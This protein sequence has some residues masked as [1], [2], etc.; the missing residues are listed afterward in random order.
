MV[1]GVYVL[2]GLC[3]AGFSTGGT[4]GAEVLERSVGLKLHIGEYCGQPYPGAELGAYYQ[5][6]LEQDKRNNSGY[7]L[8]TNKFTFL[9]WLGCH[10]SQRHLPGSISFHERQAGPYGSLTTVWKA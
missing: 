7:I 8:I 3:R 4:S 10:H 6:T 1:L 9:D 5:E 2:Y